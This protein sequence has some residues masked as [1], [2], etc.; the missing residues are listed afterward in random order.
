MN[1]PSEPRPV[2]SVESPS[3]RPIRR[4][5]AGQRVGYC[6]LAYICLA[7]AALEGSEGNSHWAALFAAMGVGCAYAAWARLGWLISCTVLGILGGLQVGVTADAQDGPRELALFAALGALFGV[8]AG[9]LL[10]GRPSSPAEP[11]PADVVA[12]GRRGRGNPRT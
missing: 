6:L 11:D 5:E 12:A 4:H 10:D 8:C 9:I 7:P 1:A 3:R 2:I